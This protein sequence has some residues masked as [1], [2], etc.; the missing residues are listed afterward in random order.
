MKLAPLLLALALS[1]CALF[2]PGGPDLGALADEVALYRGDVVAL[3][4]LAPPDLQDDMLDLQ[5][6]MVEVEAAL[7][8]A[9]QGE[10]L[11]DAYDYARAALAI[12]DA[13]A[14]RLPEGNDLRFAVAVARVLLNHLAAGRV[15]D[16][17]GVVPPPG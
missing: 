4:P 7:R 1:S 15:E 6:A 9:D 12:A 5:V 8:A 13:I 3:A 10:P 2:R 17:A 14:A 16:A 11:Q